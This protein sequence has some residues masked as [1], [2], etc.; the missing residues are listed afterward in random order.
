MTDTQRK[1]LA[2][3][4]AALATLLIVGSQLLLADPSPSPTTLAV[5]ATSPSASINP[6]ATL[7]ASTSTQPKI[8]WS[9]ASINV[10]LSPGESTSSDL[11]FT[12]SSSLTNVVLE[13]VPA[14]GRFVTI[15]P[16]TFASVPANQ[17][18]SVRISFSIS[19]AS[20]LGAY[21]GTIHLRLGSRTIP[22]PLPI[23]IDVWHL[24]SDTVH[25]FTLKYP[26]TW[27]LASSHDAAFLYSATTIA[28]LAQGDV[29]TP[30]DISIHVFP[31]PSGLPLLSVINSYRLGWYANYRQVTPGS[32]DAHESIFVNDTNAAIPQV[33]QLAAR[34]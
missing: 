23:G 11:T 6:V 1:W 21:D 30:A 26:P 24:F 10:I 28:Q 27:R 29:E 2:V 8:T 9:T 34:V 31:N 18:Q 17:P 22:Q 12:S 5:T 14:I 16:N 25:G 7:A 15:R 20:T 19:V 13:A 33:P 4:A 3:V 32:V